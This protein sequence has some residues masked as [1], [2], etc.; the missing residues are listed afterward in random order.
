M[1]RMIRQADN[2]DNKL[3]VSLIDYFDYTKEGITPNCNRCADD[4]ESVSTIFN[5]VL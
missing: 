2:T 3:K 5:K 4:N 1:L